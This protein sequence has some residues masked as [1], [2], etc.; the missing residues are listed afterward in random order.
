MKP[1]HKACC[2]SLAQVS[3]I[4]TKLNT[5]KDKTLYQSSGISRHVRHILDHCLALKNGLENNYID[6]NQRNRDGKVESDIEFA[7]EVICYLNNWLA[8]LEDNDLKLTIETEIDIDE[9]IN[10]CFETNQDRE[11][12]NMINHTIHHTAYI[13]L[14][15]I[16]F[17]I[18]FPEQ[19]GIAPSTATYLRE[20]SIGN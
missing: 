3:L 6:Y 18:A 2:S 14:I 20:E 17:D 12:L 13:K 15:A 10:A 5:H 4:L 11:L 16:K 8:T 9:Q 1:L 19:I 7:A